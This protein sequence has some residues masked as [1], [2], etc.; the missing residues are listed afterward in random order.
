MNIP[1]QLH[2]QL[3]ARAAEQGTSIRDF[4]LELLRK[5]GIT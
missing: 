3:K 5:N 2:R 1:A 4:I